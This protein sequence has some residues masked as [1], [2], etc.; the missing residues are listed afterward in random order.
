MLADNGVLEARE[1]SKIFGD[2]TVLNKVSV[3]LHPGRVHVVAGANGSGKS[4]L[5]KVLSG[6]YR[7]DRGSV[8]LDGN[9]RIFRSPHDCLR[10]GIYRVPQEP[11]LF[12]DLSVAENIFAGILPSINVRG[13]VAWK[14]IRDQAENVLTKL[15]L[16]LRVNAAARSLTIAE[17]QILECARALVHECRI[18]L[19]D[20]PTSPL[21][22]QEV[23]RL[24]EVIEG[25]KDTGHTI[26]FISHRQGEVFRLADDIT[27]LRNGA[28]V[29]S[30]AASDF[31]DDTLVFAMLGSRIHGRNSQINEDPKKHSS[32]VVQTGLSSMNG[33]KDPPILTVEGLS[34]PPEVKA[35]TFSLY[36]GE[37]VGL[38]GLVG[39][40][41]TETAEAI[42][43]IRAMRSGTLIYQNQ[44][45]TRPSPALM[46]YLGV[47]YIPEDR[48]MHSIFPGLSGV[49]NASVAN[50]SQILTLWGWLNRKKEGSLAEDIAKQLKIPHDRLLVPIAKLS[51]GSQQKI[52]VGRWLATEPKVAIF[53]EPTRGVDVG[54]KEEIYALTKALAQNG[55]AVLYISSEFQEFESV[56]DRVLIMHDGT[57]TRE[58]VGNEITESNVLL[59][60]SKDM[61]AMRN[62]AVSER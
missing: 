52:I 4:V 37:V 15:G 57:I 61:E 26:A 27:V 38:G 51:G 36:P 7:P 23:D 30:S 33:R 22:P 3:T 40:G 44:Q 25:L 32:M 19:F 35:V 17:Q 10:H 43:G 29:Q 48:K 21:T 53:D 55:M 8:F 59:Y 60:A 47:C 9:A 49:V 45:L 12:P 6:Y 54:V 50:L 20:E 56:V 41:R 14:Q 42:L 2:V 39:A 11:L 5:L 18:I 1:V 62:N 34:S 13:L 58:L 16:S 28:L 46:R 24:F 31:D